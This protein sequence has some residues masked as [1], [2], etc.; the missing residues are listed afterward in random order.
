MATAKPKPVFDGATLSPRLKPNSDPR[1]V[2]LPIGKAV[3][4]G[5]AAV[6]RAYKHAAG[7]SNTYAP[8]VVDMIYHMSREGRLGD[9][10]IT[11]FVRA[12]L[13]A[14]RDGP[15]PP[16]PATWDQLVFLSA[17][18]TRLV[19][20]PYRERCDS[21]VKIGGAHQKPLVLDWPIVF[22]GVDL[23]RLPP[24]AFNAM[25]DAAVKSS[26]AVCVGQDCLASGH[27]KVQKICLVDVGEPVGDL[28][29]AAAVEITAPNASQLNAATVGPVIESVRD[30]TDSCI[31]VGLAAPAFNA[32]AVIDQTIE[33]EPD[34]YVSD[35]QWTGDSRPA[36]VIPELLAAPALHVLA[37]TVDSLRRHRREE[38]ISVIYRG[39]VRGGA[40]AGKAL[41][42]GATAVTLGIGGLVAM[43]HK[44]TRI[45]NEQALIEQLGQPVDADKAA[46]G[47]YNFAKSVNIE[48]TM[49]ARACGKSSVVNMEP[50]DL[51]ALTIAVSAATGI[52]VT[53][54]DINFRLSS[55][56]QADR[57]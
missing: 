57:V 18:L 37:D 6:A 29:A 11:E 14:E 36:N 44:I 7:K 12:K 16:P 53:G 47:V 55:D 40:D 32:A 52:P 23:S 56:P 4:E 38:L 24:L 9:E 19:I 49:L 35:A 27:P 42:L 51:R 30:R 1:V 26:C 39:G 34:F 33:L 17:N 46:S 28:T 25:A 2:A 3:G 22:G 50:E 45:D 10:Y 15:H 8:E 48:V 5:G 13:A 20:D 31:P 41:C 54:K 43:G 21:R